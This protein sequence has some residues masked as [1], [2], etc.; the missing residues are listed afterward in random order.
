MDLSFTAI[1]DELTS[2]LSGGPFRFRLIVQPVMAAILGVRAG[3]ADAK[4]GMSPFILGLLTRRA[5]SKSHV[6]TALRHLTVPVL[7]ATVLDALVQYIMFGHIR[8]LTALIVGTLL[9]STPYSLAR[10][11]SNRVRTRR[12][13]GPQQWV[14]READ[15]K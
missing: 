2:R 8:P 14:K 9:M 7:I 15:Q 11:L 4:S 12:G 1:L 13:V 10:A 6:K 5:V 3:V